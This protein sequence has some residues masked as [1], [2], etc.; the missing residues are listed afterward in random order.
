MLL[1]KL[2]TLLPFQYRVLARH[3]NGVAMTGPE[4]AALGG[5]PVDTVR[6]LSRMTTWAGIRI[7]V[8]SKF[9]HG[10]RVDP[11]HL[12]YHLRYIRRMGKTNKPRVFNRTTSAYYSRLIRIAEEARR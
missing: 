8:A 2:D 6:R 9:M 3:R 7:G 10:C 1:G 4:I 12:K 5:L 11:F